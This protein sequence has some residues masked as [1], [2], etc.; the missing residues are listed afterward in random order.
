MQARH[1]LE[2]AQ[3]DLDALQKEV[4]KGFTPTALVSEGDLRERI[5]QRKAAFPPFDDSE[6]YK[7][8]SKELEDLKKSVPEIPVVDTSEFDKELNEVNAKIEAASNKAG[9]RAQYDKQTKQIEDVQADMKKM[10]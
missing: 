7:N 4:D 8:L 2:T 3:A 1:R 10:A 6:E 9:L 5:Q